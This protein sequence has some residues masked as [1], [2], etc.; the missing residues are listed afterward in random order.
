MNARIK[1]VVDEFLEL[2]DAERDL[3]VSEI[4]A[5]IARGDEPEEEDVSAEELARRI[6]DVV[7][8]RVQAPDL[9]E[10]LSELRSRYDRR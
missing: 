6:D 2:S 5:A 3:A 10:A 8:G 1:K 9:D 4:E 7:S